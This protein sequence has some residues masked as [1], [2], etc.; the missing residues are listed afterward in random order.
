MIISVTGHRDVEAEPGELVTFARLCVARMVQ[1]GVEEI[2]TGMARGWDLAIAKAAFDL[3]VPYCAAVPFPSQARLWKFHDQRDWELAMS[4]AAR[5][6]TLGRFALDKYFLQCNE[7]MVDHSH[8]LWSFWRGSPGG[9][10]HCTLYAE[11][12]GVRVVPLWE[13]WI[14]FL[15]E[16]GGQS[17]APHAASPTG[18]ELPDP[19]KPR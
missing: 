3:G 9:T 7:W 1:G 13:A 16:T 19:R 11:R 10:S 17:H 5:V 18:R 4:R 6:V 12:K 8:E 14:R 2:I 15:E